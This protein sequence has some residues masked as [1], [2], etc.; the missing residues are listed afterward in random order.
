[1]EDIAKVAANYFEN[2]FKVGTCHQ[3]DDCLN[4]VTH[5]I[6]DCLNA[7]TH[8]V[9]PDMQQFLSSDFTTEEIKAELFQMGPTKAPGPDGMNALFY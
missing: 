9:T 3:I 1:M 7:V 5:K 4:A 6:D 2:L 8:K